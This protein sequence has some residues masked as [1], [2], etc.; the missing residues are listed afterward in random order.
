MSVRSISL[1]LCPQGELTAEPVTN[2]SFASLLAESASK[3]AANQA[4]LI[5]QEKERQ[6][7]KRA[8]DLENQRKAEEA[9][10]LAEERRKEREAREKK[11]EQERQKKKDAIPKTNNLYQLKQERIKRGLNPDGSED[12]LAGQANSSRV[13]RLVGNLQSCRFPFTYNLL[14]IASSKAI[15]YITTQECRQIQILL[16]QF[17]EIEGKRKSERRNRTCR[18]DSTREG[19]SEE[20]CFIQGGR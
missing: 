12:H 17:F 13:S 15:L 16:K 10:K 5:K 7:A 19:C 8:L 9:K 18:I 4:N 20:R 2:Q 11:L 3:T 1:E 14:D 6:A